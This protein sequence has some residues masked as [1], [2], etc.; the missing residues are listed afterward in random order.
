MFVVVVLMVVSS[1]GGSVWRKQ[2]DF[3]RAYIHVF[4]V[5]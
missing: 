2:A 4:E 3:L 5:K 1:V